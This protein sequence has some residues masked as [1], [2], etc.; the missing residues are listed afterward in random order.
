[1]LVYSGVTKDENS[2]VVGGCT[3]SL[4][5]TLDDVLVDR[6]ISDAVTGAFTFTTT[7]LAEQYYLV[8]YKDGTPA[9]GGTTVNT[10]VGT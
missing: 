4:F 10:L 8:L 2:A 7:G 5:R 9:L 6:V 3:V 1:M